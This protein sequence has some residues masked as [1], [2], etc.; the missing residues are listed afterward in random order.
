MFAVSYSFCDARTVKISQSLHACSSIRIC[1]QNGNTALIMASKHGHMSCAKLLTGK[2]AEV[3]QANN[4]SINHLHA[5]TCF[6]I[7]ANVRTRVCAIGKLLIAIYSLKACVNIPINQFR[8]S[9]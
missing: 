9:K 4:V 7:C 1:S 5:Y 6:R 8:V 3:N 2:R